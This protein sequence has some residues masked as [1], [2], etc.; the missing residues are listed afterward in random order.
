MALSDACRT[1]Y[2]VIALTGLV[3]TGA[4]AQDANPARYPDLAAALQSA[5]QGKAVLATHDPKMIGETNRIA[6]E[7]GLD[8][9]QYEFSMLFGIQR[10]E[11]LRLLGRIHS[12]AEARQAVELAYKS[13]F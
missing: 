2:L 9:D 3:A 5:G 13:N 4:S 6:Y 11:Q 12:A 8:R 10:D 7:L 1:L